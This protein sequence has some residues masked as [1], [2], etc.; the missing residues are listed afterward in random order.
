MGTGE[1]TAT[2]DQPI[3]ETLRRKWAEGKLTSAD[4]Q[5]IAAG[6]TK[7]GAKGREL[8]AK[9]WA[10]GKHLGNAF[11]DFARL[12]GVPSG[13]PQVSFFEVPSVRGPTQLAF[14]LP[15]EFFASFYRE[16]NARWLKNIRGKDL[17]ALDFG[18]E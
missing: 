3:K 17:D 7:A 16:E 15:H 9:T 4:V 5:E 12:L 18:L 1:G 2:D 14:L 10:G 8:H 6:A 13:A 11:K